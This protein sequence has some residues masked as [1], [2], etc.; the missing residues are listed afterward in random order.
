MDVYLADTGVRLRTASRIG[1]EGDENLLCPAYSHIKKSGY[2]GEV[3][4]D[5]NILQSF[6][7]CDTFTEQVIIPNCKRFMLDSGAFTFFGKGKAVNWDEY[8]QKYAQFIT[9]NK[10]E[11]YFELDI[12]PLVGYRKVLEYRRM[13]ENMTGR[14]CIPVWHKSRGIDEYYKMCEQYAYVA[15]GGIVSKEITKDDYKFFP[16]LISEAHKRGA[17][18]HGL[19]FTSVSELKKYHFDSVDSSSWTTGNRFGVTYRFTGSGIESIKQR[20]GTRI[21]DHGELARH[22]FREWAKFQQYAETHL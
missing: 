8:I 17:K 16:R 5:T 7:Y 13:L 4:R 1:V 6:F 2:D 11:R 18:V 12:D 3:F 21:A 10:V 15:I 22:N 19:G 14:P 9:R 20:D